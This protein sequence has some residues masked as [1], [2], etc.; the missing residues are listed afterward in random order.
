PELAGKLAKAILRLAAEGH[1]RMLGIDH[2]LN[3]TGVAALRR[4]RVEM[5]VHGDRI[6]GYF[7]RRRIVPFADHFDRVPLLARGLQHFLDTIVTVA[8]HRCAGDTAHFEHLA[9]AR[10]V[11]HQPFGPILAESFLV[12]V[13][14]D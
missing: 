14:V 7:L 5:L 2:G 10:Y 13:D 1:E 4:D 11:L 12:D 3:N 9:A 6:R 8:I